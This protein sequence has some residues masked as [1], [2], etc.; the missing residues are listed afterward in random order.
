VAAVTMAT[1]A[2]TLLRSG[3]LQRQPRPLDASGHGWAA[4]CC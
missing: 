1:N 3:D 2:S 4:A